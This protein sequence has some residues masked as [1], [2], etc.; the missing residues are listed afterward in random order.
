RTEA[1]GLPSGRILSLVATA[2]GTIA[3]TAQGFGL[4]TET[5]PL[6]WGPTP[7]DLGED[8]TATIRFAR[9]HEKTSSIEVLDMARLIEEVSPWFQSDE[10]RDRTIELI[11]QI[12]G[13]DPHERDD[14]SALIA[15]AENIAAISEVLAPVLSR[16]DERFDAEQIQRILG[17]GYSLNVH[18]LEEYFLFGTSSA[19]YS[20]PVLEPNAT[21]SR[22]LDRSATDVCSVPGWPRPLALIGED[23]F[24]LGLATS[25]I[26]DPVR[27][28]GSQNVLSSRTL[29]GL[30]PVRLNGE[31]SVLA[32]LTDEGASL[33]NG[34][35]VEH[36]DAPDSLVDRRPGFRAL[37]SGD[38][39]VVFVSDDGVF[40]VDRGRAHQ[41]RSGSGPVRDLVHHDDWDMTFFADSERVGQLGVTAGGLEQATMLQT[42]NARL[43]IADDG[44]LLAFDGTQL[45][46]WTEPEADFEVLFRTDGTPTDQNALRYPSLLVDSGG[47]IWCAVGSRLYCLEPESTEPT[48]WSYFDDAESFPARSDMIA[49]VIETFDGRI[50]IIASSEGHRR[51]PDGVWLVGGVLELDV[52]RFVRVETIE[53]NDPWFITGYATIDDGRALA[54]TADGLAWHTDEGLELIST[55]TDP[56]F[57]VVSDRVPTKWLGSQPLKMDDSLWLV[58]TASGL[59]GWREGSG[60]FVADRMNWMLPRQELSQLGGRHVYDMARTIGGDLVV[61]S[62]YGAMLYRGMASDPLSF[63]ASEGLGG[64]G[65]DIVSRRRLKD[66][67]DVLL[68]AQPAGEA[69][70]LVRRLRSIEADLSQRTIDPGH[71]SQGNAPEAEGARRLRED[72]EYQNRV[73][74]MRLRQ[75]YPAVF[76]LM[77]VR[78]LDYQHIAR[79]LEDN[80]ALIQY[81]PTSD[82]LY[83]HVVRPDHPPA[84]VL[85][86]NVTLSDLRSVILGERPVDGGQ[87]PRVGPEPLISLMRRGAAIDHVGEVD[88][89]DRA[90]LDQLRSLLHSL[91][92]ALL[93]PAEPY[94]EGVD[95]LIIVP[96]DALCYVPFSALIRDPDAGDGGYAV[97]RYAFSFLHSI[98]LLDLLQ[99][100]EGIGMGM[101]VA[102]GDLAGVDREAD[103]VVDLLRELLPAGVEFLSGDQASRDN[104]ERLLPMTEVLHVASH[105]RFDA[106]HPENS[107]IELAND[108]LDVA[109]VMGLSLQNARLVVLSA[110]ETAA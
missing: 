75:K 84:L 53:D 19:V 76:Q 36:L 79:G 44:S 57:G 43:A 18:T 104:I 73:T 22:I 37:A 80:Q 16:T 55:D 100:I 3:T 93:R 45:V 62:S 33:H 23:V 20:V 67:L 91:Y 64:I 69:A 28:P 1:E 27:L 35:T 5:G 56:S 103:R 78:P 97:S 105:A 50:W 32:I 106:A 108:R 92:K 60:W 94:L 17:E 7:G 51:S 82:Q 11:W 59:I 47:R 70:H 46:R 96:A 8:Q 81:W 110:C 54:S 15:N 90:Q 77:D 42:R 109:A 99:S 63:L 49:N 21:P 87:V 71:A 68:R 14:D 52:D 30:A 25:D 24:G 83:I 39:G 58:G 98:Q 13:V 38:T 41:M 29:Y 101:V 4:V 40:I 9:L 12:A 65:F 86:R 89:D 88:A 102:S 66:E 74:L 61:G 85:V 2:S 95:E 34:E 72:L 31:D 6:P 107:Y 10:E 26:S 48:V